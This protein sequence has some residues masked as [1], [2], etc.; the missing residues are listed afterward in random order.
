MVIHANTTLGQCVAQHPK[1]A[2]VLEALQL[3]YCCGGD[4]TI[5]AACADKGMD[6]Q[7]VTTQLNRAAAEPTTTAGVDIATMSLTEL[8]DHIEQ[9]HHAYLREELPRLSA[10]LDKVVAA[11]ADRHP[12]LLQLQAAFAELRAELEPHMLKEE[13]ILFP[14][15]RILEAAVDRPQ[16][17]FGTVANPIRMMEHE[18]DAAGDGLKRI[19]SL[20]GEFSPPE[21]ACNTYLVM[22]DALQ[23]LERDL[24]SHI[25]K[26]NNVL[27]PR[28]Q[29]L[30]DSRTR[31][32]P[33]IT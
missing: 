14:A 8:C 7:Q 11:H 21:D 33:K 32:V 9:T 18:H 4:A 25:H 24:H 27:F 10:S 6:V 16:F 17:P 20:T 23:Q 26:E 19:R 13:R 15:I 22:F 2:R 29:S 5:A 3:D 1:T 28:A 12:E 30:E 31:A